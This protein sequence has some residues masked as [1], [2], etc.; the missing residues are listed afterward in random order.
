MSHRGTWDSSDDFLTGDFREEDAEF[1]I[2]ALQC[3]TAKEM[4]YLTVTDS[5]CLCFKMQICYNNFR[6]IS[7]N[8]FSASSKSSS[9]QISII[10]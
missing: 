9:E 4:N 6:N 5:E 1:Y 8:F 3:N 10:P 2:N 7:E